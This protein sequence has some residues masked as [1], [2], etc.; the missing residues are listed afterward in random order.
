MF[1]V[2]IINYH[3]R[4]TAD[5]RL[6]VH[7]HRADRLGILVSGA[8]L[9]HC[10]LPAGVALAFPLLAEGGEAYHHS[11]WHSILGGLALAAV[12][13]TLLGRGRPLGR[14]LVAAALAGITLLAVG[15]WGQ[16]PAPGEMVATVLGS[17]T[18]LGVHAA[19]WLRASRPVAVSPPY[20]SGSS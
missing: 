5:T 6:P 18:L 12:L 11:V 17:L 7:S 13:W 4:V 2:R 19:R 3:Y 20:E 14:R 15:L 10:L 1:A 9:L 8:C 16:L